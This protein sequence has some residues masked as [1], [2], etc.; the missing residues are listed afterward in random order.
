M[1]ERRRRGCQE[2]GESDLG[3]DPEAVDEL[4]D[5]AVEEMT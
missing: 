4:E 1:C 5:E 3:V 2:A